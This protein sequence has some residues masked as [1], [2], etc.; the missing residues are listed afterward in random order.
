MHPATYLFLSYVFFF[1]LY[2]FCL[3]F[4]ESNLT[5]CFSLFFFSC[6]LFSW[7]IVR[8]TLEARR[9][10]VAMGRVFGVQQKSNCGLMGK[11]DG[12]LENFRGFRCMTP[13]R[14]S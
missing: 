14:D 7:G 3:P 12:A 13:G 11:L 8:T 1:L 2:L 4:H 6:F 5:G 10:G 9:G